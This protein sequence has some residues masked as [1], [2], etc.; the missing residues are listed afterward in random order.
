MVVATGS[1]EATGVVG[2]TDVVWTGWVGATDVVVPGLVGGTG[3]DL[4][5]R[6]DDDLMGRTDVGLPG[7]LEDSQSST[8][9]TV[10]TGLATDN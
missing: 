4:M 8:T 3:V 6:T 10:G 5:G 9:K 2:S 1:E 7:L